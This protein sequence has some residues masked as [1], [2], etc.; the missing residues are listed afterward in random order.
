MGAIGMVTG[1]N[2]IESIIMEKQRK[3]VLAIH[4]AKFA[5]S[6][7]RNWQRNHAA[8]PKHLLQLKK[9]ILPQRWR[10]PRE[11]WSQWSELL[12]NPGITIKGM[13]DLQSEPLTAKMIYDAIQKL[14]ENWRPK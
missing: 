9:P 6:A 4:R 1:L 8:I 10:G 11:G 5:M 3:R 14:G 13:P 2:A 7:H 12:I